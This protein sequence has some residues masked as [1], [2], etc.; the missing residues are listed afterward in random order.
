MT[1]RVLTV[2]L[3]AGLLVAWLAASG[4][5]QPGDR[6]QHGPF[7]GPPGGRDFR[8]RIKAADKNGDGKISEQEASGRLARMFV[9]I[10]AN[11]DGVLDEAELKTMAERFDRGRPGTGDGGSAEEGKTAPDFTLKS[12]DGKRKVTL[13]SFA[14]K[15]PVA[16]IFGSYT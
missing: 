3:T 1:N 7:S 5:A 9:R 4:L 2:V 6:R 8:E 11:S 15:R 14:G 16:L 10:D 13:S 12:V